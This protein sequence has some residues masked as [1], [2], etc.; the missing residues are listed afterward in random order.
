MRE[1]CNIVINS[2]YL[3]TF[4]QPIETLHVSKKIVVADIFSVRIRYSYEN[5]VYKMWKPIFLVVR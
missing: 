3:R 5:P 4:T 1:Y 2:E